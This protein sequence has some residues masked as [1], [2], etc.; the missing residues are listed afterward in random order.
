M[1]YRARLG[2]SNGTWEV[3]GFMNYTAHHHSTA[4]APSNVNNQCATAGG[5]LPKGT[6][7]CELQGYSGLIPSTYLFDVS[8]GYD[9]GDAPTN[10]YLKHLQVNF[11]VTK[12]LT[13]W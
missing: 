4:S 8:I 1:N 12:H 3:T 7:P 2:W 11:V 6:F 5:T 9:T 10:D 13:L